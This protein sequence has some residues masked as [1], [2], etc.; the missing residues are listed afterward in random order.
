[1]LAHIPGEVGYGWIDR[2]AVAVT[3]DV[4]TDF[5]IAVVAGGRVAGDVPLGIKGDILLR[6]DVVTAALDRAVHR[7]GIGM[8][9]FAGVLA[10]PAVIGQSLMPIANHL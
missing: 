10:Y 3:V 9:I 7:C 2:G 4:V 6:V 1:M 5:S 8:A